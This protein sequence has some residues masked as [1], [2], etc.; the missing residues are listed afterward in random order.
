MRLETKK[1]IVAGLGART[2]RRAVIDAV[3]KRP[4]HAWLE[5]DLLKK[6]GH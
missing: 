1:W 3:L 6:P 5:K 2:G 4:E